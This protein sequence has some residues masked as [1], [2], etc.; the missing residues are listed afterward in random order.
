MMKRTGL[1][2][3]PDGACAGAGEASANETTEHASAAKREITPTSRFPGE[4]YSPGALA[5]SGDLPLPP[6]A[7]RNGPAG[8]DAGK[9]DRTCHGNGKRRDRCSRS[10]RHLDKSPD[11]Q[12][13]PAGDSMASQREPSKGEDKGR[14]LPFRPRMSRSWNPKLRLRDQSRSSVSDLSEY[15]RAPEEDNYAHRMFI[16]L[17]ALLVLLLIVGCGVWLADNISERKDQDCGRISR[18]NCTPIPAP[19]DTR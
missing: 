7:R 1:A 4:A 11:E 6:P 14:I 8:L 16:N 3:N 18:E 15:S 17:L 5:Q 2:G 12:H 13:M 10:E 9:T 19:A